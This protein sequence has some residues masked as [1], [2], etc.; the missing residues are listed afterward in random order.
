MQNFFDPTEYEEVFNPMYGRVH[1]VTLTLL[2]LT[3]PLMIWQK[4]RI[5]KMVANCRFMVIWMISYMV[6]DYIYWISMW[7][8]KV[9]PLFERFP[10]HLCASM[11]V[12]L[13]LLVL[14]KQSKALSFFTG[15]SICAG[16]IS[17]INP[18]FIHDPLW[19]FGFIHYIIRHFFIF[20]MPIFL[21]IGKQTELKS[22]TYLKSVITL[23]VYACLIFLL[24]W[25][26]GAN[27]M[28]L[29]QNNPLEIPFL[30]ERFTQWPLTLPTFIAVGLILLYFTYLC[31]LPAIRYRKGIGSSEK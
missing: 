28:H 12:L 4:D 22:S 7:V 17:F 24:D 15:W 2:L 14:F 3:I 6:I 9:Q 1:L 30:P 29:G 23:A 19:S 25:A 31:F 18:S 20:L 16:F 10:L 21:F 13:P 8:F 26:T 11:S 27:Y 5:V